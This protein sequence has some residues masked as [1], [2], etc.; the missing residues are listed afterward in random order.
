MAVYTQLIETDVKTLL[1]EF[2]LGELVSY[3]GI[4]GGI[5]NTNYFVTTR[6]S[7]SEKQFVLT[8][9]EEL[10]EDEM[11]FF[12]ELTG[13]LANKGIPVPAPL[14]DQNGIA[15]KNLSQRPALLLPRF[16]GSQVTQLTPHHCSQIGDALARMHQVGRDF[17]LNRQAHRGVFWW[18]RESKNIASYLSTEDAELLRQEVELF[19]ELREQPWDLPSGII[20]GD[21]FHDNA[22][23]ENNQLQGII[24]LYNASTGY[25]LYDLAIVVNDWCVQADGSMD[26]LRLD[27]LLNAYAAQRPF[28]A[29]EDKAWPVLLRTAAMRFWLSRLISLHGLG[30]NRYEG[31]QVIKNPEE[32]RRILLA[33]IANTAELPVS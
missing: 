19:D 16:P 26:S 22:L 25:L 33:H 7:N 23:F 12:V 2:N 32:C 21:L 20:H 6:Q 3:Q 17:Y 5:E 27:A 10:S 11:P 13:F 30:E 28:E 18:R 9:F 15:L 31:D 29:N 4:E 24:D 8:L 14:K 1:A